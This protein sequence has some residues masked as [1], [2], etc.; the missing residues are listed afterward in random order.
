MHKL[1][2][3]KVHSIII[4]AGPAGSSAAIKLA[5]AGLNVVLIDRAM[6]IGSKNLSGG[7]LWGN[8]LAE[9]LPDWRDNA[10]IERIII[11]KKIGMLSEENSLILDLN[12]GTWKNEPQ[13]GVSVLRSKFDEWLSKEAENAG[14]AVLSGILIDSL[15]IE[16]G[17]VVGVRQGNEELRA[18]SVIIAEG[19]N[20]RLL[21][22][23]GLTKDPNKTQ[24]KRDEMMLGI[25]EVYSMDQTALETQFLLDPDTGMAG[26]FILGNVPGD[27]LSGGFFYTNKN[28]LS[29]GVVIHLDSLNTGDKSYNVIEYYKR[30]PYIKKLMRYTTKLEEY[31]AKLIPEFNYNKMPPLY[32]DGYLVIGDAAGFVF[33]NGLV[34]Q[35][36]NYAI[37]SGI[38]AAETIIEANKQNDF[39][40]KTLKLYRKKLEKSYILKD[41][42]TFRKVKKV[43]KNKRLFKTYP[44]LVTDVFDDFLHEK[45]KPKKHII[46]SM[47]STFRKNK[48]GLDKIIWDGLQFR[49]L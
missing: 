34:I 11:R 12:F 26:E 40:K 47:L 2:M 22:K 19:S 35:G 32:G 7:V 49:H 43:T 3:D 36:M 6:P 14:V 9:I 16:N 13:P 1:E 21:L 17:K 5:Q 33:S 29:I 45:G 20:A 48:V 18:D 44:K 25:K 24:F 28:T 31:G 46:K 23:H 38:L 42:K 15:I 41:F 10:P 4:G 30:H 8:D 39:T 37:K 27:V